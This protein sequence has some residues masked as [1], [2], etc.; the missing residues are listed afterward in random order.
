MDPIEQKPARLYPNADRGSA[1]IN[2]MPTRLSTN[3]DDPSKKEGDTK[4]LVHI[5]DVLSQKK[6][7]TPYKTSSVHTFKDDMAAESSKGNFSIGKIVMANSKKAHEEE[8]NNRN[9]QDTNN[10]IGIKLGVIF[11]CIIIIGALAYLG[12]NLAKTPQEVSNQANPTEQVV[13]GILYSEQNVTLPVNNKTK[14]NIYKDISKEISS[15]KIPTGKMK[16]L[17]FT[18]QEGASTTQISAS[19]F[20]NLIAPSAPDILVRNIRKE[21][22]FGYYSYD[23]S[24]PFIILK[25]SNY[26]SVFAGMLDWEK[27]MYA[28]LGELLVNKDSISVAP[29][30]I[31]S[32]STTSTTPTPSTTDTVI[33]TEYDTGFVDK[34][35]S[36]NDTRVLYRQNGNI[37]FFYTFFNKDTVII[38]TS[39][40]SLRE[41][42]YRLTS[43][44]ITR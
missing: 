14:A 39:E 13:N 37:A 6:N 27:S 24:E 20:L 4:P 33:K 44:K 23:T 26:D 11:L 29:T 32:A 28:D 9:A 30:N 1:G 7:D 21:Y 5:Q 18:Y 3:A 15:V 41:I 35:I 16:S 31:T 34:I 2:V 12:L 36:N 38:A 17:I 40:Q 43:G 42:I 25:S 19:D 10:H 8:N 22:V